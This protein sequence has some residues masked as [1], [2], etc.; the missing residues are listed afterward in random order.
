MSTSNEVKG[1]KVNLDS[2]GLWVAVNA[3]T[4]QVGYGHLLRAAVRDANS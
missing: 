1:C 3:K 2:D 4:G